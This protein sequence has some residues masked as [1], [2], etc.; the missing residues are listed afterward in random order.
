MRILLPILDMLGFSASFLCALHCLFL[1]LLLTFGASSGITWLEHPLLEWGLIALAI[2]FACS[3]LFSSFR[4][5]KQAGP[6]WLAFFGFSILFGIHFL[7]AYVEHYAAALGGFLIA[8][9]HA[10]NWRLSHQH[11]DSSE[12]A[13]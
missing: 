9:A 10:W 5:H 8:L 6:L 3:S 12:V 11:E 7:E 4:K 1:P 2:I 13:L